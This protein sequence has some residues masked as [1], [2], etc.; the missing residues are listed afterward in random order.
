LHDLETQVLVAQSLLIVPITTAGLKI[1]QVVKPPGRWYRMSQTGEELIN[2]VN[3]QVTLGTVPVF[4]RGGKIIPA[5]AQVGACAKDAISSAF[6]LYIALDENET[7]E[8]ELY[9]DDG[10]TYQYL[11]GEYIAKRFVFSGGELKAINENVG[12]KVPQAFQKT[13]IKQILLYGKGGM[14]MYHVNLTLMDDFVYT[15]RY[16]ETTP[17][18]EGQQDL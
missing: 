1:V 4:L 7:A 11:E 14:T 9:L 10:E 16:D 3:L 5:V 17:K 2:N 8:G 18:A 12:G 6:V 15:F 13:Q